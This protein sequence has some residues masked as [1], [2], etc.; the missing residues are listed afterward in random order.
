MSFGS[1]SRTTEPAVLPDASFRS[2]PG[3]N[4]RSAEVR[5]RASFSAV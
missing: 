1:R 3:G 2:E 5:I 4:D